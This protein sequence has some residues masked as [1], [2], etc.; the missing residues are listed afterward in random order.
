MGIE[1]TVQGKSR[2]QW[3]RVDSTGKEQGTVGVE[4]T[5][6]GKR[7]IRWD[8]VDSTGKEQGTVGWS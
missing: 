2:I 4:L 8:R 1:L 3:D 5:V 6:Q 7:R